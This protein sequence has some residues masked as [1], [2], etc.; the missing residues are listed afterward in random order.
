VG[1]VS[2]CVANTRPLL[3]SVG[4]SAAV[5][6]TVLSCEVGAAKPTEQIYLEATAALGVLPEDAIFVDDQ[7]RFCLGAESVGMQSC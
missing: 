7:V 4:L 1:L 3:D 5:D 6:A 2:N